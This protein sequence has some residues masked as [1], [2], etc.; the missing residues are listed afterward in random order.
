MNHINLSCQG[1]NNACPL[2]ITV[3][4]N[5]ITEVSGNCCHRGVVSAHTQFQNHYLKEA[6][7]DNV[8]FTGEQNI[9]CSGCSN[10]CALTVTM[11]DGKV[12]SVSG[13]GCRRGIVSARK[14]LEI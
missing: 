11:R 6:S 10:R 2:V 3:E 13:E 8:R 12:V 7:P 9:D 14:Q 1:C 5:E 4:N